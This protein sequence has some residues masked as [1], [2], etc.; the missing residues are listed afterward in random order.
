[1]ER[2][3]WDGQTQRYRDRETGRFVKTATIL[4]LTEGNMQQK[5]DRML[6]SFEEVKAGRITFAEY[7]RENL[8]IIKYLHTKQYLVAKGGFRTTTPEDYLEIARE[9]KDL[10][11]PSFRNF[12]EQLQNGTLTEAQ[13]RAR[14][15]T[16]GIASETM[17][18]L[19]YRSSAKQNG[20]TWARRY[21]SAVEHCSDCPIYAAM[22]AVTIDNLIL[23]GRQCECRFNCKCYVKYF[24]SRESA[25]SG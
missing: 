4:E 11:Y 16:F 12:T 2:Y 10:H 7:Q 13:A 17:A 23:P 9:L 25:V 21:L 15:R 1:M 18:D 14:I 19:G 22:G 24:K 5:T 8:E 3:K 20:F 6:Q